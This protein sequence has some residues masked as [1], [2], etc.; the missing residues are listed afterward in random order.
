[1]KKI[2][3]LLIMLCSFGAFSDSV[4]W[5]DVRTAAEFNTGHLEGAVNIPHGDIANEISGLT[6]DKN[7]EIYVYCRSGGRAG[8]ALNTL[9]KLGY[10]QVINKGGYDDIVEKMEAKPTPN[11]Y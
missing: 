4:Y 5:I 9:T 11:P 2:L 10:T 6:Q 7:A 1:M 8:K 3:T